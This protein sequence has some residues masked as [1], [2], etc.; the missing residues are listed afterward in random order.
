M[1][2]IVLAVLACIA[3]AV[4]A[5][6]DTT[7][8]A[9][10][11]LV[12]CVDT[13]PASCDAAAVTAQEHFER[14]VRV[15]MARVA[16]QIQG[17][18]ATGLTTTQWIKRASLAASVLSSHIAVDGTPSSGV[19]IWLPVFLEAVAEVSTATPTSTD[20]DIEFLVTSAWDDIAG[21]R[22]IDLLGGVN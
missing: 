12:H 20:A 7:S 3:L 13:V 19:A 6:G 14:Q 18:V 16:K 5:W 1:Q 21:V 15:S 10:W 4:P 2:R 8:D 22:G 11:N 9:S 17:E